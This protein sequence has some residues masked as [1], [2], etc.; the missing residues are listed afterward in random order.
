MNVLFLVQKVQK[1]SGR[2][3]SVINITKYYHLSSC[4]DLLKKRND[5]NICQAID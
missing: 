1:Y 5:I 3:F 4:I 2:I